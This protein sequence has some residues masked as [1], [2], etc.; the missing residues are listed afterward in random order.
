LRAVI[1]EEMERVMPGV[2]REIGLR[3]P[4]CGHEFG[5][6]FDP[7][8]WL[9]G[10]VRRGRALLDRDIHLL[11]LHY[12]WPLDTILAMTGPARREYVSL[13]ER[14]LDLATS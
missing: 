12:H 5:A 8:A 1:E 9:L 4:E 14:E 3:C 13:L 7:V 2:P 6:A 11:S 10:R